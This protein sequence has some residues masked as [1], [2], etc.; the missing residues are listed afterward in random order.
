HRGRGPYHPRG[1]YREPPHLLRA[2]LLVRHAGDAGT[3]RRRHRPGGALA[4]GAIIDPRIWWSPC[5]SGMMPDE[6]WARKWK[7]VGEGIVVGGTKTAFRRRTVP[8]LDSPSAPERQYKAF[9]T[10]AERG[11]EPHA[12]RRASLLRPLARRGGHPGDT[13]Q[14]V[15]GARAGC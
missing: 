4:P 10:A 5:C 7:V 1:H 12:L 14:A 6:L 13:P 3:A 15:H 11:R 2:D 9:R 8:L